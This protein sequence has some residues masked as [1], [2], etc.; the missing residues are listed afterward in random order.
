MLVIIALMVLSIICGIACYVIA[1]KWR[2][3]PILWIVM[4]LFLGPFA[5]AFA[6][7]TAPSATKD[8]E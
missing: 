5:I 6:L 1:L 4:G 3:N 2:M 8:S 7:L